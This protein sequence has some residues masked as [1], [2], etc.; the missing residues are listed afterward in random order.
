MFTMCPWWL[1]DNLKQ[2]IIIGKWTLNKK[3]K[4]KKKKLPKDL[5]EGKSLVLFLISDKW[6]KTQPIVGNAIPGQVALRY[7]RKQAKQAMQSEPLSNV[8]PQPLLQFL[9]GVLALTS[10]HDKLHL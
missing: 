6:Q 10:L 4:K 2:A 9:P 7:I 1:S 5:S 3:K 8:P